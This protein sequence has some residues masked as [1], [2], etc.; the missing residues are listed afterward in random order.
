MIQAP[1]DVKTWAFWCADNTATEAAVA[2][3][4]RFACTFSHCSLPLLCLA[5]FTGL[6]AD[7]FVVVADA[8]ALIWLGGP[9]LANIG[10]DLPYQLAICAVDKDQ[11][12]AIFN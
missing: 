1:V 8:F 6:A 2:A 5:C 7:G 3:F 9:Q 12:P 11:T 10:G 4:S